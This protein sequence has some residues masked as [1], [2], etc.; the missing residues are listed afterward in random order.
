MPTGET[1]VEHLL[2]VIHAGFSIRIGVDGR[3]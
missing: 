3:I 2:K 1:G